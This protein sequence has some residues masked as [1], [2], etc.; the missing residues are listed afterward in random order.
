MDTGGPEIAHGI[1]QRRIHFMERH[2]F[3]FRD[4]N[5]GMDPLQGTA[6]KPPSCSDISAPRPTTALSESVNIPMET[7]GCYLVIRMVSSNTGSQISTTL[8]FSKPTQ[9]PSAIL[10]LPLPMPN[11]LQPPTTARSASG[12][13][14]KGSWSAL[15]LGTVGTSNQS[16]GTLQKA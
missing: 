1:K 8:K 16:T 7:T 15:Y 5:A 9:S 10:V 4:Y 14:T 11:S 12:T 6:N 3:Q 2:G 13:L